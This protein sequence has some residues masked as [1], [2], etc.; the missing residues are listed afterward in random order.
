MPV[1]RNKRRSKLAPVMRRDSSRQLRD[2]YGGGKS[3][4]GAA[5]DGEVDDDPWAG[6]RARAGF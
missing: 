4:V 5:E 1:A 3:A 2:F 6:M